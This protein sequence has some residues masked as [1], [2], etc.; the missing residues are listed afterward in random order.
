MTNKE[1]EECYNKCI[2]YS[3]KIKNPILRECCQEIYKD[4]K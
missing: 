1:I 2:E 4:Y 3:N